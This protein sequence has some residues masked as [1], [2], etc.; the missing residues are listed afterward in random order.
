MEIVIEIDI[1]MVLLEEVLVGWFIGFGLR[2]LEIGGVGVS[3]GIFGGVA[4][5][6][7]GVVDDGV[8]FLGGRPG[9][10]VDVVG[11]SLLLVEM[12]ALLGLGAVENDEIRLLGFAG[13]GGWVAV[14]Y[15]GVSG[16][17]VVKG[18]AGCEVL[19]IH[20]RFIINNG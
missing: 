18:V 20:Y 2:F 15:D 9:D 12:V 13:L 7:I 1:G 6:V 8:S 5:L 16:G 17:V 19:T 11:V 10:G 14:F 3:V 4:I